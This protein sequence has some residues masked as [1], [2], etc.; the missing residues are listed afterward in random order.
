MQKKISDL[1]DINTNNLKQNKSKKRILKLNSQAINIPVWSCWRRRGERER[2][3]KEK[4]I[5]E[6]IPSQNFSKFVK[7][8]QQQQTV[9]L[10]SKNS[11]KPKQKKQNKKLHTKKNHI[12][13]VTVMMKEESQ[14]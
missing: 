3:K 8:Q 2:N 6:E 4:R 5:L 14:K 1:T 11:V 13:T 9:N 7:K 12:Q 10:Q